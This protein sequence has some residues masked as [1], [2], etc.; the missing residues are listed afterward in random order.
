MLSVRAAAILGLV[1]VLAPL[2]CASG[3][4]TSLMPSVPATVGLYTGLQGSQVPTAAQ[5]TAIGKTSSVVVAT[6]SRMSNYQGALVQANPAIRLLVY[7]N[8]MFSTGGDPAGMPESWYL[9]SSGGARVQ[10]KAHLGNFLMNPLSTKAFT[11]GG[12]T[13]TG[14]TDYVTRECQRD[15]TALTS[16]CFLDTTGTAPLSPG[17]DLNGAVPLDPRTGMPFTYQAYMTMTSA[18]AAAVQ[19]A[20]GL[21]IIAN[22]FQSGN[23]YYKKSTNMIDTTGT[24]AGEAEV[25]MQAGSWAQNVQM[26]IDNARNGTG[27]L[28]NYDASTSVPLEQAR[29]FATASFLIGRGPHQ[30]LQF[31]DSAH[32]SYEQL[33]PLYQMPIGAPVETFT[34]VSSYLQGGVYQRDFT[35][36]K[37]LANPGSSTVTVALGGAYTD[38][39]GTTMTSVKLA[40]KTGIVL[41]RAAG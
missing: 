23:A 19:Q 37:A 2:A 10:P 31:S 3:T 41:V 28:L 34:N 13:Y 20:T 6:P 25:W 35:N 16:G 1:G 38:V 12:V 17:Y 40:P 32:H 8:G 11:T 14:W 26:L 4:T 24:V 21:S 5:L 29:E 36:G 9:H 15:Q 33:S 30:F 22:A 27:A 7:E 18:H 39:N